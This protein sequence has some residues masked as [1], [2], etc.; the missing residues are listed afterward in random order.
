MNILDAVFLGIIEGLTEFLPVSSTGHLM[1]TARLLKV[2][3]TEFLKS[4]EIAIQLGAIS[5]VIVLY[6][7]SLVLDH[8]IIKRVCV[9]FLPTAVIGLALYK[10]IKNYLLG[11]VR[12]VLLSLFLGGI[13]LIVFETFRR[14]RPEAEEKIE[15]ITYRQAFL[16][17]IAQSLA[18]I[19]GVSRSAATIIA[20]LMLGLK[21]TT[22]AEFSFLLAVPTMLAA[23]ALD[24][25]KT[26]HQFTR[27]EAGLL[28]VGLLVSFLVALA[29]IKFF[30][31]FIKKNSFIT[32]GVYRIL[33][34][35]ALFIFFSYNQ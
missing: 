4:F 8:E 5:S 1:I 35:I 27:E 21:R 34:A 3:T 6:F 7:R 11:D 16:I 2:P 24:L 29:S 12:I 26:A 32:F 28:A 23:T 20:G 17:G 33:I 9:A 10:V 22:I 30:L 31:S 13:F 15:A 25:L 18:V 14:P 19:P